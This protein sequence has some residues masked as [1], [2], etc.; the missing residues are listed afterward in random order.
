MLNGVGASEGGLFPIEFG[1]LKLV[2]TSQ[3]S[4]RR[5]KSTVTSVEMVT[6]L[7]YLCQPTRLRLRMSVALL[8]DLDPEHPQRGQAAEEHQQRGGGRHGGAGP[9]GE[10]LE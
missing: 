7:M 4:G 2:A 6:P 9:E 10:V 5:M 3:Y 8:S 1:F